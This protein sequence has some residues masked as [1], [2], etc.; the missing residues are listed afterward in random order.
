[1]TVTIN[2]VEQVQDVL[3]LAFEILEL[4]SC[5]W[6]EGLGR[7]IHLMP[8]LAV[9]IACDVR[10]EITPVPHVSWSVPPRDVTAELPVSVLHVAAV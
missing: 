5:G 2:T 4:E 9:D 3:D 1:M 6:K 8:R 7:A 10:Y